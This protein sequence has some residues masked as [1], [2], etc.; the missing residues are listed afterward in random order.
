MLG[1]EI[2]HVDHFHAAERVQVEAKLHHLDLEAIG[3][4]ASIPISLWQAGY[5]KDE[6]LEA[7]REGLRIAAAAGYSPQGAVNLLERWVQIH[8]E[9]VIHAETPPDELSQVAIEGLTGY[10]RSHPLPSER[11]AQANAVIAQ[12]RLP[13]NAP[14]KP[15][16]VEYEITR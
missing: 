8:R 2:E 16:Q 9:Y 5:S 10:F 6:E 3:E 12:D 4:V 11:L 14:L 1:H 13:T 7:D 15:F